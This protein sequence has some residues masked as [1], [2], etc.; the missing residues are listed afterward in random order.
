MRIAIIGASGTGKTTLAKE[1]SERT[2]LPYLPTRT[3]DMA[4]KLFGEPKPYLADE[5][6]RRSE[7][8]RAVQDDK[9]SAESTTPHF[10]TDRSFLD[11]LAYSAMHDAN[12]TASDPAFVSDAFRMTAECYDL[13]I[14]CHME[15]FFNSG[16]DPARKLSQSYQSIYECTLSGLVLRM[17]QMYPKTVL[18]LRGPTPDSRDSLIANIIRAMDLEASNA[19]K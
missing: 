19:S 17:S 1:I 7:F 12:G 13:I 3:R 8:Q 4:E 9:Y 5:L 10:V 6:G 16:D 11:N 2:G 14:F 15:D 18:T